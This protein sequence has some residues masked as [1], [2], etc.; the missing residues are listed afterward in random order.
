MPK[1]RHYD[2]L[3]TAPFITFSCYR[4]HKL[5]TA[6]PVI[7]AFLETLQTIRLRHQ[8]RIFGH[9]VMPEHVHVVLHPRKT[10]RL[11]PIIGE[12]KSK[13][14]NWPVNRDSGSGQVST[15][16]PVSQMYRW[17]WMRFVNLMDKNETHPKGGPPGLI[18]C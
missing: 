15:G 8:M 11:G 5:L 13:S 6:K 10:L 3:N 2:H 18:F 7:L 14:A 4:R 12:L 16:T 1:L 9:V 17:Q